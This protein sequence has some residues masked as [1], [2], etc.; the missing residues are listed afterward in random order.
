M[1]LTVCPLSNLKLCVVEDLKAHPMKRML[2][3]G[4]KATCNSDDPSYF[5]G[6][7][8]DNYVRTAEALGLTREEL[9][10]LARNS[11]SGSFLTGPEIAVHLRA[12]DA[13]MS[14]LD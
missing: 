9:A 12:I 1:T 7:V 2:D 6:Y 11:F 3:L 13:Y 14:A 8:G 10:T 4:L 5:G